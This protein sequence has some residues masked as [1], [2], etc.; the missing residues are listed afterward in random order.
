ME[1][2]IDFFVI[3][4]NAA[5]VSLTSALYLCCISIRA[6]PSSAFLFRRNKKHLRSWKIR[7]LL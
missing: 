7:C 2:G 5:I 4:E 1:A 6:L 3:F